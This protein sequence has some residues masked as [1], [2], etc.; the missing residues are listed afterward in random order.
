MKLLQAQDDPQDIANIACASSTSIYEF[1]SIDGFIESPNYPNDYL[2]DED[3]QWYLNPSGGIPD[4]QVSITFVFSHPLMLLYSWNVTC[5]ALTIFSLWQSKKY[6]D[7]RL[8]IAAFFNLD[9]FTRGKL[10][11]GE[12]WG[13]G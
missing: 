9:F 12:D 3:C 6:S 1:N 4:G 5:Y 7:R 8:N 2:D 10:V 11:A 13:E